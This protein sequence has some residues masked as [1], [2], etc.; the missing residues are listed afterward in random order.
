VTGTTGGPLA[1]LRVLEV[2][3]PLSEYAGKLLADFGA[4]VVLVE[5]PAGAARRHL[6]PFIDDQPGTER[7]LSFAYFHTSK[8]GIT[9]DLDQADGQALFA[10]LAQTAEVVLD[11]TGQPGLMSGRGLGYAALAAV[12]P[13]LVY[14]AVTPFGSDGPYAGYQATDIILMA[15]GGLLSLG[16]YAGGDPV[17]AGGDQACL[18]AGQFAAVGT[19]LAVLAAE[20]TGAG[21][22]VDVSA[23]EAVV[24][25]HENAVQYYDLEKVI[26]H[27]NGGDVRQAAVGMYECQDGYVYV[28]AKGLGEF[29]K[30]LVEWLEAEQIEGAASLR[31]P[32]WQSDEFA[33]SPVG[34]AEFAEIFGRLARHRTKAQLYEAAKRA[35]IPLSPVNNPA[36]L[37]ASP[38]LAARAFFVTVEHPPTGRRLTMPGAPARLT[39]SPARVRRPAPA[40]GE[41]NLELL[42]ELGLTPDDAVRLA[43]AEVI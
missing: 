37:V 2:A 11:G 15:L 36:D 3:G 1:G 26:R 13:R 16:G 25:A 39:A 29:W 27:R 43:A 21:Q 17:R 30:Q 34:K 8:R 28:L 6:G 19:M 35:R 32:R 18:A 4:D 22:F 33:S 7:S 14:T 24:M 5:P 23:Q 20:E 38:Q 31:H 41:H 9:L 12:R 40:L 10:R 42:A